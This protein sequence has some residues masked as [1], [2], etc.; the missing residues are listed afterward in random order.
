MAGIESLLA[1]AANPRAFALANPSLGLPKAGDNVVVAGIGRV[2]LDPAQQRHDLRAGLILRER[3]G[4][5]GG[6][7]KEG[8]QNGDC[9]SCEDTQSE[10]PALSHR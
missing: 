9:H 1:P 6:N 4:D 3:C 5:I 8:G 10:I 2:A 7:E